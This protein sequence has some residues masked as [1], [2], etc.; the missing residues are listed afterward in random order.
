MP[1]K[2]T[3]KKTAARPAKKTTKKKVTSGPVKKSARGTSD[4]PVTERRERFLATLKKMGAKNAQSSVTSTAIAAKDGKLTRFDCYCLG[5]HTNALVQEGV[6][7]I[8][9]AEGERELGYYL[10]AKGRKT[11]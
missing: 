8:A 5:Y 10:T 9:K 2:K 6:V 7:E 4:L 11:V 1:T 3:A